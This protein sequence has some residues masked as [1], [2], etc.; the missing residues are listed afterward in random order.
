ML[1]V[2]Q[3]SWLLPLLLLQKECC[4]ELKSVISFSSGFF[5]FVFPSLGD[6]SRPPE[7]P[8]ALLT[9]GDVSSFPEGT[10]VTYK[11]KE[12][13]VKVPGKADSVVCL[14]NAWSE[15]AEFCNRKFF[16]FV[17]I[18]YGNG[19]YLDSL[20]LSLFSMSGN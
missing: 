5:V 15:L 13:F 9:M 16:I 6:C 19:L 14:N 1:Q 18:S 12:G 7:V 11:C 17:Y 10:T 4:F 3:K 2:H 20:I 8:N